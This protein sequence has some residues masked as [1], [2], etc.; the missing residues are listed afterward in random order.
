MAPSNNDLPPG[1]LGVRDPVAALLPVDQP[2]VHLGRKGSGRGE[3][4]GGEENKVRGDH[5]K[6]WRGESISEG[7]GVMG[8]ELRNEWSRVFSAMVEH[9]YES[10]TIGE[11][12]G[13]MG[14]QLRKAR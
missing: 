8:T 1:P 3:N 12:V 7:V 2:D 4:K 13:V 14:T 6:N 5:A 9:E 11:G 10:I